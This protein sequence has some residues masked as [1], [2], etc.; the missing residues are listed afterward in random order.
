[1]NSTAIARF[2]TDDRGGFGLNLGLRLGS[3]KAA[4]G[5][6]QDPNPDLF[7]AGDS[8][9]SNLDIAVAGASSTANADII[10]GGAS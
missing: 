6:G 5:V 3:G 2:L 9:T 8:S 7:V 10:L 4:G 1:M